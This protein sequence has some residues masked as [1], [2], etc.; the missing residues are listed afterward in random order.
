MFFYVSTQ[1]HSTFK[2]VCLHKSVTLHTPWTALLNSIQLHLKKNG[3]GGD[4]TKRHSVKFRD[5][6][7]NKL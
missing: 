3:G 5:R 7:K 4:K 2:R 6:N 1:H